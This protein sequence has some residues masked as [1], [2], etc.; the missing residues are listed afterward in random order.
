M[1]RNQQWQVSVPILHP[2]C[3]QSHLCHRNSRPHQNG[4]NIAGLALSAMHE[5]IADGKAP[6]M[7]A[8]KILQEVAFGKVTRPPG[9]YDFIPH[10]Q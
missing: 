10:I 7:Q 1:Q 5:K 8:R 4:Y 2:A 3:H 6:R 9:Y